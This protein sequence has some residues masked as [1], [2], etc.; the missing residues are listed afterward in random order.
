M[1]SGYIFSS[2]VICQLRSGL[3]IVSSESNLNTFTVQLPRAHSSLWTKE[4]LRVSI[5]PE[6][7][8]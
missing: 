7:Y 2:E 5:D 6:V 8:Q 3:A 4:I 1:W